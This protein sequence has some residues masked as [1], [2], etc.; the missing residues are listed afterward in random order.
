MRG[1]RAET[2][3]DISRGNNYGKQ[4]DLSQ[5]GAGFA[6]RQEEK[7]WWKR[8]EAFEKLDKLE[9]EMNGASTPQERGP[10][11]GK[12]NDAMRKISKRDVLKDIA[13]KEKA[14]APVTG[15]EIHKY[16][17]DKDKAESERLAS[18]HKY[19]Q[20]KVNVGTGQLPTLP[21]LR[22]G[23]EQLQSSF[24]FGKAP[25]GLSGAGIP[26]GARKDVAFGLSPN[27]IPMS[28]PSNMKGMGG[29]MKEPGSLGE[30]K[31]T[32]AGPGVTSA[33]KMAT[34]MPAASSMSQLA[35][36]YAGSP[37]GAGGQPIKIIIECA[38]EFKAIIDTLRAHDVEMYR[39]TSSRSVG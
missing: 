14:N 31:A 22:G 6:G 16:Y 27:A 10:A 13:A 39:Q 17:E 18:I 21:A 26:F 36:G 1:S 4:Y 15:D 25:F 19:A 9:A 11:E 5:Q 23:P 24:G 33:D 7:M 30:T 2:A 37:G 20:D 12:W 38:P 28:G 35:S 32:S 29:G 3:F 34:G 8:P